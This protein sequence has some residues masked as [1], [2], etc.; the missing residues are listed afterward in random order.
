MLFRSSGLMGICRR[1]F[2]GTISAG[3]VRRK[4]AGLDVLPSHHHLSQTIPFLE[5]QPAQMVE[6]FIA[7]MFLHPP[8]RI[9]LFGIIPPPQIQIF[10]F[11]PLI[12]FSIIVMSKVIGKAKATLMLIPSSLP[13]TVV[14]FTCNQTH[15]A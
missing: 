5:T 1:V 15:H 4:V 8:L 7:I 13:Q 2:K 9:Q 14:T 11:T 6:E 10:P 12:P 3:T